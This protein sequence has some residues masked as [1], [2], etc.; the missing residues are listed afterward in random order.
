MF[1]SQP[2]PKKLPRHGSIPTIELSSDEDKITKSRIGGKDDPV[3]I[4]D[5]SDEVDAG[6]PPAVRRNIRKSALPKEILARRKTLPAS[7]KP[8]DSTKPNKFDRKDEVP[9]INL[10]DSDE[11]ASGTGA[12]S[13]T[14]LAKAVSGGSVGG[15]SLPSVTQTESKGTVSNK[16]ASASLGSGPQS[17]SAPPAA[18]SST[19][20]VPM[21]I[22]LNDD[23]DDDDDYN[24]GKYYNNDED[25]GADSDRNPVIDI[26]N[27]VG[28]V[29]ISDSSPAGPVT[30]AKPNSLS[31][32][33]SMIDN[34]ERQSHDS[35]IIS[36]R[37]SAQHLELS[38]C[39]DLPRSPKRGESHVLSSPIQLAHAVRSPSPDTQM[40]EAPFSDD[41]DE[42]DLLLEVN[43]NESPLKAKDKGR[44]PRSL[45]HVATP[46]VSGAAR[47]SPTLTKELQ[48]L[49]LSNMV[50]AGGLESQGQETDLQEESQK[51]DSCPVSHSPSVLMPSPVL[52]DPLRSSLAQG[53]D[54]KKESDSSA[55]SKS[56][57][58]SAQQ[59]QSRSVLSETQKLQSPEKHASSKRRSPSPWSAH[60]RQPESNMFGFYQSTKRQFRRPPAKGDTPNNDANI[61]SKPL[62]DAFSATAERTNDNSALSSRSDRSISER[63]P[64]VPPSDDV[65]KQPPSTP[66]FEA[67][68]N[69]V[70]SR[71]SKADTINSPAGT[72]AKPQVVM[73][74]SEPSRSK[75]LLSTPIKR[76]HVPNLTSSRHSLEH[77]DGQIEKLADAREPA[78]SV[79]GP[80]PSNL[81]SESTPHLATAGNDDGRSIQTATPETVI[82]RRD[83]DDKAE[84]MET[85]RKMMKL[86]PSLFGSS[87]LRT[88]SPKSGLTKTAAGASPANESPTKRGSN[89]VLGQIRGMFKEKSKLNNRQVATANITS[90]PT[91]EQT[92]LEEKQRAQ[93]NIDPSQDTK[94]TANLEQATPSSLTQQETPTL[95]SDSHLQNGLQALEP[96]STVPVA[97]VGSSGSKVGGMD[98]TASPAR[99]NVQDTINVQ[100]INAIASSS[101]DIAADILQTDI[102]VHTDSEPLHAPVQRSRKRL[103]SAS[104]KH[105]QTDANQ[106]KDDNEVRGLSK[107]PRIL[108]DTSNN[109]TNID[110]VLQEPLL[111]GSIP[112]LST[113]S[114]RSQSHSSTSTIDPMDLL[115]V[116][117]DDGQDSLLGQPRSPV[118]EITVGVDEVTIISKPTTHSPPLEIDRYFVERDYGAVYR[119]AVDI[120]KELVNEVNDI[121][122]W[123]RDPDLLRQVF[124]SAI[125]TN[126]THDEPNAPYIQLIN[127]IDDDPTPP[128]E[129]Y[130][131]NHLWHGEGV[132]P[133]DYQNLQGC[134]CIGKCDPR[135]KTCAC[136]K[137]Q[138]D[139][140]S[141][142]DFMLDGFI[143]DEKGRLRM[144]NI[145]IFECNDACGC[146]DDCRNRVV[147]HGRKC[148]V[149]IVK[150][151]NK[152]WGVFAGKR[153]PKGTFIGIYS[154]ELL[155]EEEAEMRGLVYDKLGR[156][157]L[158]DI[159]FWHI[160]KAEG[161][162]CRYC[163]DAF[164]AGNN[165]SCEPNCRI[166]ACHI[167]DAD[168]EKALL[169]IFAERDISAGE[170]LCFSYLGD[171]DNNDGD[172][173][174]S[175][176]GSPGKKAA[177]SRDK[178]CGRCE[179]GAP[180]C[181][182][183]LFSNVVG[184]RVED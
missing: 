108:K 176:L 125:M 155:L 68:D 31:A 41:A 166:N 80:L 46:A 87:A 142:T 100:G 158:F 165:H 118:S 6:S 48:R 181:T 169:T 183:V 179:C 130:Y 91:I 38:N 69:D 64:S 14:S 71:S 76:Q 85:T 133:P 33:S 88:P 143:Y 112:R 102:P 175:I 173:T 60:V 149:N 98:S 12:P 159:D 136:L 82:S 184:V 120:P 7:L 93:A 164:H 5:S 111:S 180:N 141:K 178:V 153:I 70:V 43:A 30:R 39:S 65:D 115:D 163:V 132:P 32:M 162:S 154:G 75:L 135:S 25:F 114:G 96:E 117:T 18:L 127:N 90:P 94:E 128:F 77:L 11:D 79:S 119:R 97:T 170:E 50:C 78:I 21:D 168:V 23:D 121:P 42:V 1:A 109:L 104:P 67:T 17:T 53:V 40:D 101:N 59:T 47:T 15:G 4:S 37:T 150:T 140:F 123:S 36:A 58:T 177:P 116:R 124:E 86:N 147:Q 2:N 19:V 34:T 131:T 52:V 27:R 74:E 8:L 95:L 146:T 137:R 56:G 161:E 49:D 62:T 51:L 134:D 144:H 105:T 61:P 92:K 145:P 99:V 171:D 45:E 110:G 26:G 103:R 126:T 167:N 139:A 107:R 20:V 89:D 66:T 9:L 172:D 156:T 113:P 10:V 160:P 106:G 151:A 138:R 63:V 57:S 29:R 129:F 28:G 182:G 13:D 148:H 54:E 16:D 24:N 174:K 157:Y 44:A 122:V 81:R 83:S 152:G 72:L 22:V 84:A 35:A 55:S 73:A 3:V